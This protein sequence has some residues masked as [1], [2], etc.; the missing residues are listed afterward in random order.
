MYYYIKYLRNVVVYS[1]LEIKVRDLT[2]NDEYYG[3]EYATL[4]EVTEA[5]NNYNNFILI[6][7]VLWERMSD[8]GKNYLHVLKGL[9][10]LRHLLVYTHTDYLVQETKKNLEGFRVLTIFQHIDE[11]LIDRGEEVRRLAE[12]IIALIK[13]EARLKI[14]RKQAEK[15]KFMGFPPLTT[16]S[17]WSQKTDDWESEPKMVQPAPGMLDIWTDASYHSGN[18]PQTTSTRLQSPNMIEFD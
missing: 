2:S 14:Y 12:S 8:N 10:L 17:K 1:S 7:R 11:N 4:R 6:I 15:K 16:P 9:Q 13:D 18:P 3:D 5:V